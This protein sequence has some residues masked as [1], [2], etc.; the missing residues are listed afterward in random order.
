MIVDPK[1]TTEE[2]RKASLSWQVMR[3]NDGA[4]RHDFIQRF[5]KDTAYYFHQQLT[6]EEK[7]RK[8]EL[9]QLDI[10]IDRVRPIIRRIV[11]KIVKNKPSVAALVEDFT[12]AADLS[13][14][15][16]AQ[17]QY[18]MRI[19]KGLSQI[20]RALMNCIRGGLGY[21]HV[22]VDHASTGGQKEVKFKYLTPKKVFIDFKAQDPLFDDSR[23]V[24]IL[25]KV[26]ITDAIKLFDDDE[27]IQAK[28]ISSQNTSYQ[29]EDIVDDAND[30]GGVLVGSAIEKSVDEVDN[31]ED[32]IQH[33]T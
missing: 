8:K 31:L 17:V 5:E 9:K 26:M 19:C 21:L 27:Q 22:Y 6:K 33:I 15:V 1:A 29:N 20:R 28:I 25:E 2:F 12:N 18:T 30:H 32:E 4:D 3:A 10:P 14:M 11:A 23:Q 16:N 7:D 13:R 24:Q